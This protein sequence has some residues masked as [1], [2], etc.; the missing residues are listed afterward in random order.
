MTRFRFRLQKVLELREQAER[1]RAVA[2]A[3]AQERASTLRDAR[4]SIADARNAGQETLTRSTASGTTAGRLQQM[5]FILGAMDNQLQIAESHIVTAESLVRHAQ[6]EL[7]AAF[8]ARHALETLKEKQADGH[9]TAATQAD[10]VLMDELA[11]TRFRTN[12]STPPDSER[13]TN[14]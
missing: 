12:T 5:Q 6:D 2:V 13:S 3:E 14:G 8:Q 11:L 4:D 7:R 9:R 10:R 1:T